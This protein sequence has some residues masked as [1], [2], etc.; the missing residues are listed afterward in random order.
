MASSDA[1][2]AVMERRS[3]TY[4]DLGFLTGLDPSYLNRIVRGDK[5]PSRLAALRIAKALGLRPEDVPAEPVPEAV[6]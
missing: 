4:R 3:L 6:L 1:I 5:V 2:K